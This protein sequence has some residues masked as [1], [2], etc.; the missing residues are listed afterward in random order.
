MPRNVR[1][2][3]KVVMNGRVP[4]FAIRKPLI[5]PK[6][7]PTIGHASATR[8][9]GK[10]HALWATKEPIAVTAAIDPMDKSM[11]PPT[12]TK[13]RPTASSPIWATSLNMSPLSDKPTG[14]TVSTAI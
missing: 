3:T 4:N 5:S 13:V 10:S 7:A 6:S 8:T 2:V 12:M 11:P 1:S 14:V 9:I